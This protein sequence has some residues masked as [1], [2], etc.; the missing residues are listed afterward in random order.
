MTNIT[1]KAGDYVVATKA[2][3]DIQERSVGLVGDVSGEKITI[4]FIGAN[5]TIETDC[6][7]VAYLDIKKTGKPYKKKI[8]NRCHLLKNDVEE[9][10]INQT[11]AKG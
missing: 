8:C 10:D 2:I 1:I 9:F 7:H 11:D 5:K 6:K 3:N 4:F